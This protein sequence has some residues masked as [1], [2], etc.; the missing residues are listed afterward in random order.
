MMKTVCVTSA[1]ASGSRTRS[2]YYNDPAFADYPVLY[3]SW[4]DA[5]A[6]CAWSGKRLPTEAEWEFA[7]RGPMS[8]QKLMAI[9]DDMVAKSE[10]TLS[11]LPPER[12]ADPSTD[13][14]RL[15]YLAE[16]LISVV[17]HL[18]YHTGQILWIAKSLREGAYNEVW[19]RTHKRLGGW[20]RQP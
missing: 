3:V 8:R 16:D 2:E 12:L 20:K 11:K 10:E 18:A 1:A 9:F 7:A 5:T 13:P 15:T 6:F 17:S 4:N 14:E 19:M